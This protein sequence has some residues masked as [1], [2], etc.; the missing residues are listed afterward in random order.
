MHPFVQLQQPAI[1]PVGESRDELWIW[2]ELIRR[3]DPALPSYF[4][5]EAEDAVEMMLAAGDHPGGPTHGMTLEGLREGPL[6]LNCP[7]PDIAFREQIERLEPFP[8]RVLPAPLEA[9]RKFVPTGRI[10]FYK[11]EDRFLERGKAAPT[12]KV[13]HD[14]AV[15]DPGRYPLRILSPHSKWRIHST[16]GNNPWMDEI[17]G[18]RAPVLM[19]PDDARGRGIRDGDRVEVFNGRARTVAWA[20]VTEAHRPGSVTLYEGWWRGSFA[21]GKGVNELTTSDVNPIHEIHFVANMWSPSTPWKD[22]RC[23]VRR[24]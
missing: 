13:P 1:P 12:Y 15:H 16:Y 3:I 11:E 8:P 7:D 17:H 6:R 19:H 20:Q 21:E 22:C 23:E 9:T 2:R 18:G 10:E 14:D 5:Y 24:A 4:D